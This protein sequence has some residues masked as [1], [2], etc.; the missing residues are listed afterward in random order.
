MLWPERF[1]G[2]LEYELED[3]ERRGLDGFALD[4]VELA[5]GRIVVM[6][7]TTVDGERIGL[8]VVYP[9][10]FPYFRPEV[11][12]PE[13]R[14]GRHQNPFEMN[15]CLLEASTRAWN[16][17]ETGAWLVAERVPYLLGLIREGGEELIANEVPQGEPLSYYIPRAEGTAV[18]ITNEMTE[19]P[20]TAL[21]GPAFFSFRSDRVGAALHVLLRQ[22]NADR[23]AG[24]STRL[25]TSRP[26]LEAR[27][28]GPRIEGRWLR[29]DAPPGRDPQAY[30]AANAAHGFPEPAWQR[31]GPDQVAV[32]AVLF[33]EEVQQGVWEDN[34]IF[35]VHHRTSNGGEGW[36]LT[37]TDHLDP[38]DLG[39]RV[40]R[41]AGMAE[42]SV[43]L[44]GLGSLGAPLALE[45]ARAQLGSLRVLDYDLVE[46]G[47]VVRWPVGLPAVGTSKTQ[48]IQASIANQYPYT[49]C[50]AVNRRLGVT[51]EEA[52]GE[53]DEFEILR[54]FIDGTD[55]VI[56][57]TAEIAIQ[58]VLGDL[59]SDAGI[60]QLY[61]WG[62]EGA[63]GGA[64][65][66]VIPGETGCWLCLQFALEDDS[67]VAPP[68][69]VDGST[70]P[71]GCGQRTFTGEGFNLLPVV[72]QAARAAVMTVLGEMPAGRD[73]FVMSLREGEEAA[74]APAW[75]TYALERHPRCPRCSGS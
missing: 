20:E 18:F 7:T 15:L 56:D 55:L 42:R 52:D 50:T 32:V 26:E 5:H 49:A 16:S 66:R 71:R 54:R 74:A 2:R 33:K 72:A 10:L 41:L 21:S 22:V 19:L 58:H 43:A 57:A 14:L 28:D 73:V 70:Q 1:P 3:Y 11:I 68:F 64:V 24:G 29:L 62:T 37:K 48:V 75:T 38:R 47:T 61:V 30:F 40:P 9:D 6:G 4:E 63:Y 39:A 45:L 51:R 44:A 25:A 27:F 12:A 13:L 46:G 53:D 23:R 35:A 17:S 36:Y 8:K 67:I 34:W 65:A 59:A 31:V 60:P 69:E